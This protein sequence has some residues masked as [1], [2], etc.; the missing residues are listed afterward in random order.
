MSLYFNPSSWSIG[1]LHVRLAVHLKSNQTTVDVRLSFF[2]VFSLS[3]MSFC[4]SSD[5]IGLRR[6]DMNQPLERDVPD[7]SIIDLFLSSFK[8][9]TWTRTWTRGPNKSNREDLP[10]KIKNGILSHRRKEMSFH[11]SAVK[12]GDSILHEF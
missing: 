9:W 11:C 10:E 3:N 4:L 8:R 1:L 5:R 2:F 6:W 12:L 7:M